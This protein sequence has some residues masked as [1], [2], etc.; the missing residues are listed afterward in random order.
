MSPKTWALG[1]GSSIV[2][3]LPKP[4]QFL[5]LLS[6]FFILTSTFFI[7]APAHA[8]GTTL[9]WA[10]ATPATNTFQTAIKPGAIEF[11]RDL[12]AH[13]D[14]RSEWWYYTGNLSTAEGR[15]FGYELTFFRQALTPDTQPTNPQSHWRNPQIYFAHFAISDIADRTFHFKERFSR[16]AIDLSGAQSNPYR[17]WLEDWSAE[18][19]PNTTIPTVHLQASTPDTAIDLQ[20]QQTRPPVLQGDRGLSIKGK[21]EGNASYYY[22]IVQQPTT[23][24]LTLAGKPYTV[25]GTTWKDHEYST[26][27]LDAGTIG[28]NWF[29]AQFD[30]GS[31]LML[32]IL[33]DEQ[34]H[35][36]AT[37][38][39]TYI[40]ADNQTQRLTADDWTI[41]AIDTWT[42]PTRK[43]TY[44]TQWTIAIPRL[45]L[46]LTAKALIPNQELATQTT[47][48]WEGA[49]GFTGTQQA[50]PLNGKGYVELTG[51]AD[52]LDKVLGR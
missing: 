3:Q 49:V 16:N 27:A 30:D 33:R 37:S 39:G 5:T 44:P 32:Y 34:N 4:M 2:L 12:G 52:R 13:P 47:T 17:V 31:A 24:T 36:L 50:Q 26:S 10:D 28:W 15:D 43:A 45:N 8:A 42:S 14:F 35:T 48:Y 7:P 25:T 46:N 38:A 18:S 20:V 41:N 11:P 51:Y 23:G 19:I 40:T 21:G 29:S 22:S 1:G 9:T 6:T